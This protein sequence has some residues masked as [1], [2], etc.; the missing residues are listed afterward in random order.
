MQQQLDTSPLTIGDRVFQSRLLV[1][2]GKFPS[3]QVMQSTLATCGTELVTVA[4]KRINLKATKDPFANILDFLE[5]DRY[6]I[7]PNT[8][9][10]M[11]AEEAVRI[12]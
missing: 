4:L 8:A 5:D 9:G 10:A 6:L 7:M 2:T 11:N 3:P 12:V 1:G